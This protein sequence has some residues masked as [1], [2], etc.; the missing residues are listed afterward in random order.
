MSQENVEI[1]RRAFERWTE[2]GGTVDAIPA[3]AY[4][5]DVEWDL[6]AYPLVD[7]P[8]RGSGRDNV[9]R[10]F[11]QYLSGWKSY[12]PEAREFIDAGDDVIVVLHEAARIGDSGSLLER[13]VFQVW[14]LRD[15]LVVKW[16]VFETRED[17]LGAAGLSE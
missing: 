17:A 13:D 7:L 16:R 4:A 5:E 11:A 3:E 1:T 15:G 12:R 14:T 8:S 10:V 2:G 6:S 9:L